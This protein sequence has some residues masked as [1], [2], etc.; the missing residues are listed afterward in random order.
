MHADTRTL[1]LHATGLICCAATCLPTNAKSGDLRVLS[2]RGGNL[3]RLVRK[4]RTRIKGDNER[5]APPVPH[6]SMLS[7]ELPC[8]TTEMCVFFRTRRWT[9][10]WSHINIEMRGRGVLSGT[11]AKGVCVFF[12]PDGITRLTRVT[13]RATKT[14]RTTRTFSNIASTTSTTRTTRYY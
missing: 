9:P 14:T 4:K 8:P 13:T 7:L 3:S 10:R 2:Q 11:L 5:H 12:A 1:T 6:I